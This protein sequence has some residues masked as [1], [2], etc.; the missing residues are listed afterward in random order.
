MHASVGMQASVGDADSLDLF[1]VDVRTNNI[2]CQNNSLSK[3]WG[4]AL[5]PGTS[6]PLQ[7]SSVILSVLL[8]SMLYHFT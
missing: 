6:N 1:G 7:G 3:K 4:S 5:L 2:S 8:M